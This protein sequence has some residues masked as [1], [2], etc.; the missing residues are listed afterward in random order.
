VW[1]VFHF[2]PSAQ[3]GAGLGSVKA[4][5][6]WS[7]M[8]CGLDFSLALS[9][10]TAAATSTTSPGTSKVPQ[11]D[12]QTSRGAHPSSLTQGKLHP[13]LGQREPDAHR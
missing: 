2:L 3:W 11:E 4:K 13:A 5:A 10:L 12:S 1:A 9:K 8:A 6:E 7:V